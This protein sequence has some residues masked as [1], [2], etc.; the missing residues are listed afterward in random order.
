MNPGSELP[1]RVV[2]KRE[3]TLEEPFADLQRNGLPFWK[4][5]KKGIEVRGSDGIWK[6]Y[7]R[8]ARRNPP[9]HD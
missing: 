4:G 6:P 5:R 3:K 2:G 9:A 1:V 8:G 7:V